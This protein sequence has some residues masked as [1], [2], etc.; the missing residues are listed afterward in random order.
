MSVF[1]RSNFLRWLA[2][3]LV[4]AAATLL[5]LSAVTGILAVRNWQERQAVNLSLDHGRQVIDTLDRLRTIIADLEDERHGYL[6]TLDPK[7]LKAYGVSDDSVRREAQM[8]ESLVATDP[9]QNFR[10]GHLALILSAKLREIDEIV[11]TATRDRAASA[12]QGMVRGMDDIRLQ[13]DLIKDYERLLLVN[14]ERRADALEQRK[15]WLIAAAITVVI[16]FAGV[17]LALA[18]LEAKRRRKATEENV[19]LYSD[20]AERDRK[21]RRLFDANIIG[22]IIWE[23]EGRILEANDAFLRIVGYD[24]KDL[25]AGQL[26]RT[27][28]TPSEWHAVDARNVAEMKRT[29]TISPLEK[30]YVRK[31]GS[32]VPVLVG[33]AMFE[34][35]RDRG[36][37]FVLDLTARKRAEAEAR[38]NERRYREALMELAHANRVTTMGQLTA[39]I[40]HE[41][42]QPIAAVVTNAQAGLL[43]LEALPPNLEEVRHTLECIVNDGLRAGDVIARIRALIR[44][45]P[46]QRE[47]LGINEAV[48]E[49]IAL[50]R[51]EVLKNGVVVK[52]QFADGLPR[53]QAD[54]VQLQ[55]VILNLI[56]NAI[57]AMN[58][59]SEG[60]RELSIRTDRSAANLVL[61]SLRDSGPGLDPKSV[62]HLFDAFYTTKTQ[63]MGMGLA[64][65]RSIIEAHGGR[66]WAGANEPRGAVFQFT[67]PLGP[68]EVVSVRHESSKSAVS[69]GGSATRPADPHAG[70][71]PSLK[72]RRPNTKRL[73]EVFG[74][75]RTR[76][77]NKSETRDDGLP[78]QAGR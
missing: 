40:A 35:G 65:C 44:K 14:R 28:L 4:L 16:A 70:L 8:L 13:I 67:L 32:R 17:A 51:G 34:V 72:L 41:V 6:L 54:R 60:A 5:A 49:V 36:V 30:E 23:A 56:M 1:A 18:R 9:M 19:Q 31:D 50:T 39:S 46:P 78:G 10:A 68:D 75:G 37:G 42:N 69:D 25:A 62:E 38:E 45:A 71:P 73:A 3:P 22:I 15:T 20:L 55:Q 63:G 7:Y 11:R 2:R 29:G 64:I 12:A 53:V 66:L 33:G 57:E 26:N 24:R 43:W 77:S 58:G 47:S 76:A 52:T 59:V 21:I 74:V 48:L 27:M 61:V